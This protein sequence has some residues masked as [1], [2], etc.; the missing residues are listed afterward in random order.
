MGISPGR[1][2][3]LP[4]LTGVHCHRC[5]GEF[6]EDFVLWWQIP[7]QRRKACVPQRRG[8]LCV[9]TILLRSWLPKRPWLGGKQSGAAQCRPLSLL[10]LGVP[11]ARWGRGSLRCG[12]VIDLTTEAPKSTMRFFKDDYAFVAAAGASTALRMRQAPVPPALSASQQTDAPGP[13]FEPAA[14]VV[15]SRWAKRQPW[16]A[17]ESAIAL[18]ERAWW[19]QQRLYESELAEHPFCT[20]CGETAVGSVYHRLARCPASQ[21]RREACCPDWL[22]Q[23]AKEDERNFLFCMG[24]PARP[25]TPEVPEALEWEYGGPPDGAT[26][27]GKYT[28]TA[29]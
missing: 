3:S 20:A 1:P 15:A 13:W 19:T 12:T 9:G 29:H 4:S 7:V 6:F 10:C 5:Q 27:V 28:R 14:M 2:S 11:P 25:M 24:V 17:V 22:L 18:V 8:W 21:E 16:S 26:V 23:K